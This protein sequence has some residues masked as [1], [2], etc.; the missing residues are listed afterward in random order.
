MNKEQLIT[1]E[2]LESRVSLIGDFFYWK[3]RPVTTHHDKAWN[4]KYARKRAGSLRSSEYRSIGFRINGKD[5][6]FFEHRLVFLW[7]HGHFPKDDM[8]HINGIRDDNRIENLREVGHV[9][10]GK[11]TKIY[12]TNTSGIIGVHWSTSKQKWR[13]Q[14]VVDYKQIYLGLFDDKFAAIC[15][16]KSA[17]VKYIFHENHGRAA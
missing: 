8:D 3:P 4:T 12:K 9:E 2:Y 7:L 16:R 14:I 1:Q 11:N 5:Y 10:N 6:A 13:A 17:E 15:A